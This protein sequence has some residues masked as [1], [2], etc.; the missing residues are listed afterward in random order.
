MLAAGVA[1]HEPVTPT[2]TAA[3]ATINAVL[4]AATG[5]L[6][7]LSHTS[8]TLNTG[9]IATVGHFVNDGSLSENITAWF[10]HA[11]GSPMVLI[12]LAGLCFIDGFF[13]PLPS[14]SIV[15]GLTSWSIASPPGSVVPLPLV[16]LAAA[17][18][19]M[20]GDSFA[21][22]LGTRIPVEKIKFLNA[23]KGKH[24]Y[25]LAHRT[26]HRRGTSFIFA[27]RFIPGGRVAV[28]ICAGATNFGYARFWRTDFMAVVCWVLYGM[29]IGALSG[30]LVGG[31][32]PL[33]AVAV[34]IIGGLAL[35]LVMDR[36]ASWIQKRFWDKPGSSP[37]GSSP[38]GSSPDATVS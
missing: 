29:A 27:A 24:A 25:D 35:S 26:L 11:A 19:A 31:V 2:I 36:L 14:E 6:T 5:H 28:N 4:T 21:Y 1:P 12:V 32:H 17:L 15:I 38:G 18:G 3:N 10:H 34:G 30:K 13:P 20:V 37:D 22:F 7:G 8:E 16:F 33:L 9:Y 23:G